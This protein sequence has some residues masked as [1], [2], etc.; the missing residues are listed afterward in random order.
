MRDTVSLDAALAGLGLSADPELGRELISAY[1][2][3]G[4][5][6]HNFE[7]VKACLGVF[8]QFRHLAQ[9]PHEI[10]IAIWFHDAVYDTRRDD[11]ESR[12]ADWATAYLNGHGAEES[13]TARIAGMIRA[14]KH[15]ETNDEDTALLLDVDLSILGMPP[16]V[17]AAY[18]V[19]I[20]R[21]FEWV[22]E[23]QFRD[24]RVRV[25]TGF[26]RRDR[27]FRTESMFER[28]ESQA[29]ANLAQAVESLTGEYRQ[30]DCLANN[31]E[32]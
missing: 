15:H 2:G 25:L 22:P 30:S 7:H 10:E 5:Y 4:R 9:R 17:F 6:Y 18:D 12:S 26:L 19:A 29:K 23:A 13:V 24:G 11:N 31:K 27:I 3:P 14:T 32:Q 20:R 1:N 16:D 21:E 28:Y 8:R